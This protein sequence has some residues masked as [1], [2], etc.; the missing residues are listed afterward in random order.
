MTDLSEMAGELHLETQ[1]TDY[2]K[3]LVLSPNEKYLPYWERY[4]EDQYLSECAK[5]G[6]VPAP[7]QEKLL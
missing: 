4:F 1:Q 6:I 3:R 2:P 7:V 5:L